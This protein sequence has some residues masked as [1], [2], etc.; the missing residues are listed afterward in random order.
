MSLVLTNDGALV[1][2]KNSFINN[3]ANIFY[4]GI[5]VDD[6]VP[7]VAVSLITLFPDT[8]GLTYLGDPVPGQ[9][10]LAKLLPSKWQQP[11][12]NP[13]GSGAII[14]YDTTPLS[15]QYAHNDSATAYGYV[16]FVSNND[17]SE[18]TLVWAEKFATPD[19]LVS[20]TTVSVRIKFGLKASS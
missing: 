15:F 12:L 13:S 8:A 1:L 2:L 14:S 9:P 4:V 5:Y 6:V 16:V 11:I 10:R 18:S 7:D 3:L 19:A 17:F 20:G